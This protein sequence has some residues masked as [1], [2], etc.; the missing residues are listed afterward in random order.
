MNRSYR[1]VWSAA[2]GAY[3]IAAETA[4][5]KGKSGRAVLAATVLAAVAPGAAWA[6]LKTPTSVVP[7]GGKTNT[8]IAPN[9]VPVVNID[10]PNGAGISHNKY[11]T[12]NVEAKGLVLNNTPFTQ[13]AVGQSQLAG[14]IVGNTN[15]KQAARIILNEVTSTNRS[16]LAGY[17]EVYG[18]RADVI[19]VN[20]NGLDDELAR[21]TSRHLHRVERVAEQVHED[22][23]QP[24]AVAQRIQ[25]ARLRGHAKTHALLR[26]AALDEEQ[27][28]GDGVRHRHGARPRVRL[29][30]ELA[31]LPVFFASSTMS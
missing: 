21:I 4:R 9:G 18:K 1:H 11:D 28:G 6:Q 14:G 22:L 7:N 10:S 23:L 17:T 24:V 27:R 31:Q 5:G 26:D 15:L 2:R 30:R 8:Y 19:V 20:P 3:V 16:T 13:A 25:V 29:A 12:Y